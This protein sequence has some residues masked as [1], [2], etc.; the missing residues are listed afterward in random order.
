MKA[1]RQ[2]FATQRINL[3]GPAGY[4]DLRGAIH[5]HSYLSHDS[6]GTPDEI[7]EAAKTARLDFLMMTDHNNPRIYQEGMNGWYGD[8]LVIRGAEI[9]IEG[10]YILAVGLPHDLN[11]A[12]S[13]MTEALRQV[14]ALGGV[15]IV[16]HPKRFRSWDS[17][18]YEAMEVYDLLDSIQ[19]QRWRYP[20]YFFNFLYSFNSYPEELFF[21]VIERPDWG[22][23]KWDEIGRDRKVT[24]IGTSDAHQNVK[25]FGR[26]VDPYSISLRFVNTHLLAT[27]PS[28][29]S[30]PSFNQDSVLDALRGG[31]AYVSHDLIADPTGFQFFAADETHLWIMG[32]D[33]PIGP[34]L[35]L[36]VKS[37]LPARIR[38]FKN[39]AVIRET[40]SD[41]MAFPLPAD[42][43]GVYRTELELKVLDQ[44]SPWIYSNAIY[45]K[46]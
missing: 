27:P 44:W 21:S 36:T 30:G 37:P 28:T 26:Q 3:T 7:L 25:L 6:K 10:S 39:G 46:H 40:V 14:K 22:I 13:V 5:V 43:I 42:G 41:T 45:I 33:V 18:D 4:R 8:L 29:S 20:R 2:R 12:P 11:P 38:L 23:A 34:G 32:D 31:H 17:Q 19:E 9:G 1:V 35:Q 24:A 15:A 16:A